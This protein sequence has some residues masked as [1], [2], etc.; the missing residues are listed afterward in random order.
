MKVNVAM[1]GS[2][3]YYAIPVILHNNGLLNKFY[4]DSYI[5]NKP[6]LEKILLNINK[7]KRS[8]IITKWL[9][10]KH[11]TI[12]KDKV[13][14]FEFLG[15]KYAY[16]R[17]KAKNWEE[18]EKLYES[19]NKQFCLN[20]IKQ[21]KKE[22]NNFNVFYGFNGAS[23][24]IIEFCKQN[25]KIFILEQTLVPHKIEYEILN[26]E[27]KK[28]NNYEKDGIIRNTD[29]ILVKRESQEIMLADYIIAPSAFVKD[30][31][32]NLGVKSEKII[33][34]P[35]GIETVKF[36]Y[37]IRKR[38]KNRPL[39]ILFLG[40]IGLRKGAIYLL[41][42]LKKLKP[43]I[44]VAKFAGLVS[45][46]EEILER[47]KD[48]VEFLGHIPKS[49]VKEL[50]NWADIFI[51]PSLA[52]GSSISIYEALASGIPVITTKNSGSIVE[53]DK[54]GFIVPV[55]DSDSIKD[56]IIKYYESPYLLEEHSCNAIKMRDFIDIR[57]YEEDILKLIKLLGKANDKT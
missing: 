54:T 14:S 41:E 12:P 23:L 5:G 49:D 25:K 28:F 29:S 56:A 34:I 53:D 55:R 35:Y 7:L 22:I 13:I 19:V 9:T 43:H 16:L 52:E 42:A 30:S 37:R 21:S 45:F 40:E 32:I 36:P 4:T 47:Y 39:N 50:L 18:L 44:A 31:L 46:K 10:R 3:N 15:T 27:I 51:L 11:D 33:L 24:E 57:R 6:L 48:R 8:N 2:R 1:L 26:E 17:R 38:E 20:V